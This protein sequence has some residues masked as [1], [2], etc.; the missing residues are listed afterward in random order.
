MF[1]FSMCVFPGLK[2]PNR[3][4]K[5]C[6]PW[7]LQNQI[8]PKNKVDF[9]SKQQ[10]KHTS[11]TVKKT[12]FTY[13]KRTWFKT[14][15]LNNTTAHNQNNANVLAKPTRMTLLLS[16]G[17]KYVNVWPLTSVFP[18]VGSSILRSKAITLFCR[19]ERPRKIRKITQTMLTPCGTHTKSHK[20]KAHI[21]ICPLKLVDQTD[22]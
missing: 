13:A 15:T 16:N 3:A 22:L 9:L 11:K 19:A 5:Y 17:I 14:I 18:G 7:Y 2:W 10:K 4:V 6:H 12:S 20:T 8:R 1:P 21:W